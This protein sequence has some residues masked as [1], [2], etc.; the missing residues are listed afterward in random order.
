MAS[1]KVLRWEHL[2]VLE[3]SPGGPRD[4]GCLQHAGWGRG[5]R[6]CSGEGLVSGQPWGPMGLHG[7]GLTVPQFQVGTVWYLQGQ[8]KRPRGCP[9]LWVGERLEKGQ[10]DLS[11]GPWQPE[12]H[13]LI[14]APPAGPF[15]HPLPPRLSPCSGLF[16][17]PEHLS[18]CSSQPTPPSPVGSRFECH[19]AGTTPR[20]RP[21]A[22]RVLL[23]LPLTC[24]ASSFVLFN[25]VG[26]CF[27][28]CICGSLCLPR[29]SPPVR[30]LLA[31]WCLPAPAR[32]WPP[33]T[34]GGKDL[35]LNPAPSELPPP[36]QPPFHR[37]P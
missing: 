22:S 8:L 33:F 25:T 31:R 20:P 19:L 18:L 11:K 1:A 16:H 5:R 32:C 14:A 3:G 21:P 30:L 15:L 29:V 10:G 7:E 28:V 34:I 23:P 17:C 35:D 6:V 2:I 26:N 4:P 13:S 12:P 9:H 37:G 36:C 24:L 27:C